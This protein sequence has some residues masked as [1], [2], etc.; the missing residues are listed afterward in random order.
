MYFEDV[1]ITTK[2]NPEEV[3]KFKRALK[4]LETI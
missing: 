3:F 2:D 1:E 4:H